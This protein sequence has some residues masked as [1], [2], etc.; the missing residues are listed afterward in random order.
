MMGKVRK[1]SVKMNRILKDITIRGKGELIF[2]A[3]TK[4]VQWSIKA[5]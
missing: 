4:L 5:L 2:Q 1:A 3:E